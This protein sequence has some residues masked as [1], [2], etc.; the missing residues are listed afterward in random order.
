MKKLQEAFEFLAAFFDLV[1]TF[2][3]TMGCTAND[4]FRVIPMILTLLLDNLLC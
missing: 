3:T 2:Y 1:M 4:D